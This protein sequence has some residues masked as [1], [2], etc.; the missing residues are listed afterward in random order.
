MSNQEGPALP[1][2]STSNTARDPTVIHDLPATLGMQTGVARVEVL[3][4]V[5]PDSDESGGEEEEESS[6]M[7]RTN[8]NAALPQPPYALRSFP[9]PRRNFPTLTLPLISRSCCW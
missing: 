4:S 7:V 1:W 2:A 6:R 8:L 9:P 3:W 5:A